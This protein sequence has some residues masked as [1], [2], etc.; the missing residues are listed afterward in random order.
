MMGYYTKKDEARKAAKK[1]FV[2]TRIGDWGVLVGIFLVFT[3]TGSIS[4]FDKTVDG[5]QVQSVFTSGLEITFQHRP[6]HV[7][8]TSSRVHSHHSQFEIQTSG[9]QQMRLLN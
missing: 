7:T 4:F 3:L 5:E 8:V 9:R 1:A 2:M 6:F